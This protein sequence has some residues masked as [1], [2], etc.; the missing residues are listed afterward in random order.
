MS[1][2]AAQ[3]ASQIS[4]RT[5]PQA[6]PCGGLSCSW[7]GRGRAGCPVPGRCICPPRLRTPFGGTSPRGPG[8]VRHTYPAGWSW[9]RH[10][11]QGRHGQVS[12][13][14]GVSPLVCPQAGTDPRLI[15]YW[16]PEQA[17]V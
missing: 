11:G 10:A 9:F 13:A 3:G 17:V 1:S 15:R 14:E 8:G 12:E 16:H 6:G 4:G 7:T 5:A 2:A